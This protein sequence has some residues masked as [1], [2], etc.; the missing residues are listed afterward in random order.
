MSNDLGPGVKRIALSLL[1]ASVF[2]LIPDAYATDSAGDFVNGFLKKKQI[3]GCAVMVRHDGKVV[4]SEGYGIANLEHGIRVTPQT[5]FQSGSMGKQFTPG[6]DDV[7]EEGKLVPRDRVPH[8]SV[9][10]SG[11]AI[12]VAAPPDQPPDSAIILRTFRC[13]R[14]IPKRTC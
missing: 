5:V 8:L 13:R 1:F 11:P 3:P 6:G 10:P 14:I 12:T 9:H 2:A 7:V 4:L